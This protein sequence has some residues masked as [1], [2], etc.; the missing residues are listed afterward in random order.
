V[1]AQEDFKDLG[2]STLVKLDDY[3]GHCDA[4]VHLVGDMTGADA[5]AQCAVAIRARHKDLPEILPPLGAALA[6]GAG[7]S[8]TQWEAWLALYHGKA[9]LIAQAAEGA[10]RGPAHAPTEASRAAQQA[11]LARLRAFGRYPQKDPF[12]SPDH[13]ASQ[14]AY[15]TILDL[16]AKARAEFLTTL[17]DSLTKSKGAHAA[18]VTGKALHGLG[19][20][21]KTRLA[22]EYAWRHAGDY[23]ALLFVPADTPQKLDAGLAALAGVLDLPEKEAREDEAKIRAALGWL[24]AHRGWLMILDNVDDAE[25][26]AAVEKRLAELCGGHV[27]VT[28]RSG[29][30]SAAIETFPL[31]VLSEA[32]AA[33]L[34][35]DSTKKREKTPDDA[36]LA[37]ELARE[38]DGLALALAQAG[39]YIDRQRIGFARYLALWRDKRE[40]VLAW[41]DSRV[42]SYNHDVD[43]ATTWATSVEKLTPQGRGLLEICAFLD[44]APIPKF[45]L[46][47]PFPNNNPHAEEGSQSPSRSS[48]EGAQSPSRSTEESSEGP[49]RSAE[50]FDAREALADLFAYSLASSADATESEPREPGFAVHRL[51]QDFTRRG[52]ATERRGEALMQALGW[53]DAAFAGDPQDARTWPRLDPLAPHALTVA[54]Q[55]QEAEIAAPTARLYNEVGVLYR[56]KARFAEA[57][58]LERRV[59]ALGEASYGPNHPNVAA[60]L[61]NLAALLCET[62]RPTEAEPL[63]RRALAIDEASYGPNHPDVAIR[64]NNLANLLRDTN[65]PTEAEPLYRRALAI[66]ETSYGPNHPDVAIRLN[67]LAALLD[68]TNR[69]GEAEPLY[70]RALAMAEASYGPNHPKLAT[71]L[72]NLADLLHA[73]NRLAEAE[74]LFQRALAIA[75]VSYGPNHPNV[76]TALNNLPYRSKTKPTTS[77][78]LSRYFCARSPSTRRVMGRIIPLWREI[79]TNSPDC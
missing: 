12:T 17:R 53:V 57:E 38:L 54:R 35:L 34:L 45:L 52:M 49:S 79:S 77:L 28:G 37:R 9:L 59:L 44:P 75:E 48:E 68:A 78:R 33:G 13:L 72:N 73:T 3:I 61:N 62:D 64:L 50:G 56:V 5:E 20:V 65:R 24:D 55:G 27:L 39:A 8:Y 15:T 14:I 36:A 21:G 22:V 69:H 66:T 41:F 30:F 11:H 29:D 70:R 26:A 10:P 76:A 6:A 7:V 23:A 46:D 1:K 58:T 25:A 63:Y 67:N 60:A 18:A 43:L 40:S 42:V 71:L 4:V 51:V 19:G 32:D 2:F 47:V 74:P 16:L 31:D